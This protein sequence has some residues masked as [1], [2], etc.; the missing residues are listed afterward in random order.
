MKLIFFLIFSSI[1]AVSANSYSQNVKLSLNY[2]NATVREVLSAVEK[3]SEFIFFYQDQ[4]IDLNRQV[5]IHFTDRKIDELL[6]LL[7]EG[8]DNIY[9]INDRQVII[10][11]DETKLIKQEV[12]SEEKQEKAQ[13]DTKKTIKGNVKD[14]NGLPLPGVSIVLKGTSTG[15]TSDVDGNY[16]LEVPKNAETLVFSF[17]GMKSK[18][19]IISD[20]EVINVTLEEDLMDI[21]EVV[22]IGYGQI[23]KSDVTGS[24]SSVKPDELNRG[25]VTKTTDL[26]VG[27]V[28]GLQITMPSGSPDS[29]GTIRI[30]Q[31]A[32]LNASNSPLIVV[33]GVAGESL[34]YINTEDI[35]SIN[36]LKDA[37]STAIYG[38]RGANGV[39]IVTTK[40]GAKTS[41]GQA[42]SPVFNYRGD[43]SV[44]QN[45][46]FLDVYSPDEF[47][48]E[49]LK[50]YPDYGSLLGNSSTDWQDEIYRLGFTQK[51]TISATGALQHTPYRISIG[52]QNENGTIKNT[53]KE[54]ATFALNASP[55]FF[56]EHL[57]A[58]ITLKETYTYLPASASP[59]EEA[60]FMDP[61]APIYA[62]YPNNMGLGYYM[63]GADENGTEPSDVTNP[64]ASV[65]LA[66]GHSRNYR[67]AVNLNLSYKIHGFEELTLT[68]NLGYTAH[69]YKRN[70]NVLDNAPATWDNFGGKGVGA[71]GWNESNSEIMIREYYANYTKTFNEIHSVNATVGHTYEKYYQSWEDSP[72]WLNN[73]DE[74]YEIGATGA[75]ERTLSSYFG[76]FNYSLDNK[77]LFTFTMRADAS[78]RFAPETRWGYFPSGAFGWRLKEEEFLQDFEKLSNLKLRLSYGQTGQQDINNN[79]AYQASYRSSTDEARYR[80]GDEFY[81]TYRPNAFDRSIQWEVT[82]TYNAGLDWGFFD[83]RLY[84]TIDLY[85]RFTTNLL[86]EDV[87]VPA[88]SNF[89]DTL[90]QNIGEMK[91]YGAEFSLGAYLVRKTNIEWTFNANFAYNQSEITKLT[92]YEASP[93]DTYIKT[94]SIGSSRYAQIHKVG[95][96]PYTFF[97]AKQVYDDNNKPLDGVYYNP[98]YNPDEAGSEEFVYE[99][100]N[101]ANKWDTG[102]SSLVPFYG[103]FS[104]AVVYKDWDFGMNGHFAFGQYV[105][106]ETACR[107][108]DE[109]LYDTYGLNPKNS[110]ENTPEW[111][112]EHRFSD[113]WL[114][115]GDYF[116]LDNVTAGYT[117]QK[118]FNDK[119][120]LRLSMGIQNVFMI[121]KYPGID[122]EVYSGIDGSGYPRP[123]MFM[124]T[125]NLKF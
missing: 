93:E 48:S 111:S 123:R 120:S 36:V 29:N 124:F 58:D 24:V 10:G 81:T 112:Q 114:H 4:N 109:S 117:F 46:R 96:T 95:N 73:S 37:S 122:P 121:T 87:R 89:S 113:Y 22:V 125:A 50:R 99:D 42:V 49:F 51:H 115:K 26:L 18:E 39:I 7:F 14:K 33:D 20:K 34:S 1:L 9:T 101:D 79:Y 15:I 53:S 108:S 80:I 41:N 19:V 45:T 88:G 116:K 8:T 90:D 85:K 110:I 86:M 2:N 100:S 30:R 61:T 84:G 64:V 104:T 91:S 5:S 70:W 105:F 68:A 56:N 60:A 12:E 83:N 94:G 59:V 23:R 25:S 11:L 118:V 75:S 47:R 66:R 71:N 27:K 40:K 107:A 102:K 43:F 72:T 98:S 106:W 32:S 65:D 54:I 62:N 38:S 77:Y 44:N 28:A 6:D 63:F 92:A 97:L 76:R 21:E 16:K 82:S 13:Q 55:S 67:T 119:S 74:V 69:D 3:Q 78:S 35:E 31:G 57:N 52:Y 103:G 17:I